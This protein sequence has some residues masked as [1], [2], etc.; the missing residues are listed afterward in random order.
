VRT[1]AVVAVVVLTISMC[2]FLAANFHHK[3]LPRGF[4]SPVLAM[5]MAQSMQEVKAIVGAPG[6]SDRSQM[7][8][9]Q[10]MDFLFIVAYWSEFLL[11]SV[12]LWHRTISLAKVLAVMAGLCAT[13]AAVADIRE[14]LAILEVLSVPA[15]QDNDPLVQTVRFAATFKWVLLY[16]AMIPLAFVFIGREDGRAHHGAIDRAI[17]FL[18]GLYFL[19]AATVGLIGTGLEAMRSSVAPTILFLSSLVL[20]FGLIALTAALFRS[21]SKLLQGL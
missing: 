16:T 9:Q 8:S 5:Q 11:I 19:M 12:L 21:P 20:A 7:R 18:T 1:A 13:L 14:N 3:S 2:M 15:V 4:K 10:H 17:F 6:H